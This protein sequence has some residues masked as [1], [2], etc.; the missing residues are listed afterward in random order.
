MV[1]RTSACRYGIGI[2]FLFV[3]SIP[4]LADEPGGVSDGL[5]IWLKSDGN[6]YTS[7]TD[8]AEDGESVEEWDNEAGSNEA[9]QTTESNRPT[10]T[11]G[12]INGYPALSFDGSNDFM[13][14]SYHLLRNSSYTLFSVGVRKDSGKNYVFGS[15]GGTENQ[16]L[17]LGYYSNTQ[18]RLTQWQNDLSAT[19]SAYNS[20]AIS[21]F[22]ISGSLDTSSGRVVT[23][24]R[25]GTKKSAS[26]TNTDPVSGSN[27]GRIGR[28]GR[29][30][31]PAYLNGDVAE[32][33]AY[34][35]ALSD[36]EKQRVHS[37]L[38]LKY[39]ISM[40][41]SEDYVN[42]AGTTIFD[43]DGT[44]TG[45]STNIAGIGKDDASGLT[46]SSSMSQ[47]GDAILSVSSPSSLDNNDFLIWGNNGGS[48]SYTGSDVPILVNIRL[49]RVW[50]FHE[51]GDIGT[52]TLSFDLSDINDPAPNQHSDYVLLTS[53]TGVFAEADKQDAS[54]FSDGVVTFSNISISSGDYITIGIKRGKE[55]SLGGVLT[56]L[57]LWLDANDSST[58]HTNSACTSSAP[59]N[60]DDIRC[61]EDKSGNDTH[62]TSISGDCVEGTSGTQ[63]CGV[64]TYRTNQFNEKAAL[65]F[66]RSD[67]DALRYDLDG[68]GDEWT[69]NN[70][71]MFVAIEQVGTPS[72]YY[73]FFSN[74]DSPHVPDH[75]QIDSIHSGN[76]RQFRISGITS[77]NAVFGPFDND[78]KIY[79]FRATP[80]V[81]ELYSDGR[82]QDRKTFST[83]KGPH[84]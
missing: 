67:R 23:E 32:V 17:F 19:V 27:I 61:W 11:T 70:L 9:T 81:L 29:S 79:S 73:S 26:G 64:P 48:R 75:F 6:V 71:S 58:I 20:P 66:S 21:P 5:Y 46:L 51:T 42:A 30:T 3:C 43:G 33:I 47:S 84:L 31:N 12:A 16:S 63:T 25:D 8:Q 74:G 37:Y 2:L 83:T 41:S 24:F 45:H 13:L 69:G 59:S 35:R 50:R 68:N 10:M 52:V 15:N 55:V 28:A 36:A 77:G 1:L 44:Y 39:G 18:V 62:V 72:T 56:N 38:A 40:G 49:A 54:S 4:C 82:R 60:N 53:S 80:S 7:G 78:L 14:T 57:K 34:T 65:E 22:L 76:T